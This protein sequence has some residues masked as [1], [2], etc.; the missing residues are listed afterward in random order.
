[1]NRSLRHLLTILLLLAPGAAFGWGATGHEFASGVGAEILPEEIPAF[2]R[3]PAVIAEIAVLGREL[4]RSK[5]TGDPHDRER[6]PGHFVNLDDSQRVV[7]VLTLDMLPPTREAYDTI[8]RT[9]NFTQYS[10]GYL[11]YSI[12][13]GWQQLAKDFAYW[14][15][16]SVGART[17]VDPSERAW[18]DTDRQRRE[19]LVIRDLGVWSHYVGDASQ[20]MHVSMHFDGWGPFDNPRDF[21]TKRGL[22]A[23]FEG[24]FVK[25]N[26]TRD[27][28]KAATVPYRACTCSIW[29][30]MRSLLL[31]SQAQVVPLYEL[32][33]KGA[34]VDGNPAGIAFATARLADSAS[35]LRDMIVDAWRASEDMTVGYPVIPLR[36]IESGKHILTRDDF[37]RD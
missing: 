4:D 18:F 13:D 15:A 37:G 27:A 3:Q 6:D 28:V 17:A 14:R 19:T 36:D 9:R 23:R 31:A 32:D 34:F 30:R 12:V 29:D 35:V 22:H 24:A 25:S 20:P 8:L 16:A 10:A 1:M 21:S 5:G 33:Q 7:G 26:V 2:V 11:P